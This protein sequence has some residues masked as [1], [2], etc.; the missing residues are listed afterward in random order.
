MQNLTYKL[1][2]IIS[3][4]N[5][6]RQAGYTRAMM[7][8]AKNIKKVAIMGHTMEWATELS[9]EAQGIKPVSWHNFYDQ[10]RG[11]THPL[12]M[13]NSALYEIITECLVLI[14]E[15]KRANKYLTE[16]LDAISR[17]SK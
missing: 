8:G 5:S 14:Y 15:L 1:E 11:Y 4:Y 9:K 2:W 16:E 6:T 17:I 13:D 7:E 10:L 12:L 3:Y